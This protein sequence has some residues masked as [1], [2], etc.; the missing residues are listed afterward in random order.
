M[1]NLGFDVTTLLAGLSIG[2]L[3]VAFALQNVLADIFASISIYIDKPFKKGDLS[4][5]IYFSLS[6]FLRY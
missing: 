1:S 4:F 2:G 5:F 3:A 6:S